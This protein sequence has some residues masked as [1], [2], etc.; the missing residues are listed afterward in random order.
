MAT[1]I[2]WKAS[3]AERAAAGLVLGDT[4]PTRMVDLDRSADENRSRWERAVT[5]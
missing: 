4:Y 1:P 3:A 5:A 2:K